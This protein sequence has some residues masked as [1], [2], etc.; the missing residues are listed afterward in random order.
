[1]KNLPDGMSRNAPQKPP[2]STR[3]LMALL[4]VLVLLGAIGTTASVLTARGQQAATRED[5][6][7]NRMLLQRVADLERLNGVETEEHRMR[8]ELLHADLC[9][10]V[11]AAITAAPT[12]R[13]AG[14][15]PCTP[16]ILARPL[17]TGSPR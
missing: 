14:I 6:E 2:V 3:G 15:R 7:Q 13:E 4:S 9:R 8:N 16:P 10:L 5:V 11:Y 12:L 17:P 1:M